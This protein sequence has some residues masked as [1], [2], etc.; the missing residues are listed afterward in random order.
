METPSNLLDQI[1]PLIAAAQRLGMTALGWP[2]QIEVTFSLGAKVSAPVTQTWLPA[3]ATPPR[4]PGDFTPC[5][6]QMKILDA[7]P[8]NTKLTKKQL[9]MK[10]GDRVYLKGKGGL[11]ELVRVGL[12]EL[13]A[14]GR[15][16]RSE[17]ARDMY[18]DGATPTVEGRGDD[19][20]H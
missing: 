8:G 19:E 7:L 2:T 16:W 18:G 4:D 15:Y 9:A 6:T 11:E 17:L 3:S 5:A 1:L 13:L 10:C 14:G 12:I 20:N